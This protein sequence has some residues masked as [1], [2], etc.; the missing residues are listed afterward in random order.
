MKYFEKRS[1]NIVDLDFT[2]LDITFFIAE[3]TGSKM[4]KSAY[5]KMRDA[6]FQIRGVG[7]SEKLG[8]GGTLKLIFQVTF[9]R[10]KLIKLI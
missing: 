6:Y 10:V 3:F 5:S 2:S 4:S 8:G 1:S 9:L 7:S